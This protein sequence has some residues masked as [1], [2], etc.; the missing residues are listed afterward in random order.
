[1]V[2]YSKILYGSQFSGE[3]NDL[4]IRYLVAEK[5]SKKNSF[6]LFGT[7]CKIHLSLVSAIASQLHEICNSKLS[8]CYKNGKITS[9]CVNRV[10]RKN[11]HPT[12]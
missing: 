2:L 1:M 10:L 9:D 4:K 12:R 3:K 11:V 7:P 8:Y 5:L 6:I